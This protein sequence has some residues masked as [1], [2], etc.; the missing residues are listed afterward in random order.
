MHLSTSIAPQ[1][2]SESRRDTSFFRRGRTVLARSLRLFLRRSLSRQ[3]HHYP[4]AQAFAACCK[5][6]VSRGLVP[7]E[8]VMPGRHVACCI[9]GWRVWELENSL[10][11]GLPIRGVLGLGLRRDPGRPIARCSVSDV[12]VRS[13]AHLIPGGVQGLTNM[14]PE[15]LTQ[16][17]PA[18]ALA[19]P[20]ARIF[21]WR[22]ILFLGGLDTNTPY[23]HK[24]T[25]T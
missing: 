18:E 25:A 21:A 20:N 9:C 11:L 13:P 22:L 8:G 4:S 12:R 7:A 3:L 24:Q 10:G 16:G 17:A 5:D 19:Q 2:S 6:L 14:Q 23:Q 15:P 1:F